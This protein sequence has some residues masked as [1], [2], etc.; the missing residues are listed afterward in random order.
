MGYP[1][2]LFTFRGHLSIFCS[3]SLPI[4]EF[5]VT[6]LNHS[7]HP[8][9]TQRYD[10]LNYVPQLRGF[11]RGRLKQICSSFF[12][13][14]A[15]NIQVANTGKHACIQLGSFRM[16]PKFFSN[17]CKVVFASA[18]VSAVRLPASFMNNSQRMIHAS[19]FVVL[20]D[21]YP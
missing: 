18:E 2:S 15:G 14:P 9:P 16:C 6:R 4:S 21:P 10:G 8:A 7:E 1:T 5:P 12:G 20:Q 19:I 13:F 11:H 17:T 3:Y